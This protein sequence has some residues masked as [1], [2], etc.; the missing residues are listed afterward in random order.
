MAE[1]P[2][3]HGGLD[4]LVNHLD[5]R[6][7][8]PFAR[9]LVEMM[10]EEAGIRFVRLDMTL[11]MFCEMMGVPHLREM[12]RDGDCPGRLPSGAFCGSGFP[13]QKPVESHENGVLPDFVFTTLEDAAKD[14]V[15]EFRACE[16]IE[17]FRKL[18]ERLPIYSNIEWRK[19]RSRILVF[20]FVFQVHNT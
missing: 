19:F 20:V 4:G 7:L 5:L 18:V 6:F 12:Q 3:P 15:T 14:A 8:R 2:H 9:S 16:L 13:L 17:L 10:E 1:P 11:R